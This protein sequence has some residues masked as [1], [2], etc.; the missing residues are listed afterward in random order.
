MDIKGTA[1]MVSEKL[2]NMLLETKEKR[3][4]VIQ[5]WK[6]Y[7]NGPTVLWKAKFEEK[8]EIGHLAEEISKQC[9]KWDLVSSCSF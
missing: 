1:K 2:K 4:L 8:N 9:F 6:D 3:I 5:W 7:W